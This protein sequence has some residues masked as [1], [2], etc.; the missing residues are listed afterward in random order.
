MFFMFFLLSKKNN[1]T[2]INKTFNHKTKTLVANFGFF[3][4]DSFFQEQT[5]NMF[6]KLYLHIFFDLYVKKLYQQCF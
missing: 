5:E 1:Q 2:R 6:S 3:L 4:L